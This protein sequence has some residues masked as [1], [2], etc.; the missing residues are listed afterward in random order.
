MKRPIPGGLLISIEGIDGAGKTSVAT[1]LA[2]WCGERGLAC[3]MSK[4]PTGV[5]FGETLRK[6]A[7]S[8]RLSLD[9]ELDLFMLDRREHVAR[10]ISPALKEQSIVIL[11]RYYWSTAAYQGA[12]GAD[13]TKIIDD[14]LTFAPKPDLTIL[15]DVPVTIGRARIGKRGETPNEFE[16]RKGLEKARE[17]FLQL[18]AN[19]PH[20][21]LIDGQG[22][23]KDV[24]V[25]AL[26]AFS[27]FCCSK[28]R[29]MCES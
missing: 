23:L 20:S 5:S 7:Q 19:E 15:I 22:P 26:V 2:Q 3:H 8:G 28:N 1:A 17:I 12:R 21:R 10:M 9:D 27:A 16:D 25:E 18:Q 11:D 6:S 24:I 14:N 4:E 13:A 29:G